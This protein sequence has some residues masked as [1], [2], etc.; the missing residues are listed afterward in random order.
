MWWN[1]WISYCGN[2]QVGFGWWARTHGL[3][4]LVTNRLVLVGRENTWIAYCG[5]K[6]AGFGGCGRTHGLLTLVTTDW[7][8]GIG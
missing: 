6:Q 1:T 4:T 7:F 5:N 3:L 2:K 8:W